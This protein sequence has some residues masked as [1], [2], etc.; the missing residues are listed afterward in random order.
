MNFKYSKRVGAIGIV[1]MLTLDLIFYS[2]TDNAPLRQLIV[3]LDFPGV[4]L[5]SRLLSGVHLTRG[6]AFFFDLYLILIAGLEGF[7]VGFCIDLFRWRK[8]P[9]LAALR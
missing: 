4:W 8:K 9:T 2:V 1:T 3:M 5:S 7:L 6:M